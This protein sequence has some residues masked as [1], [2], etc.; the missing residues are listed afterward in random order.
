MQ[1]MATRPILLATLAV[2]AG[3]CATPC[4]RV[5]DS[6]DSFRRTQAPIAVR[7]PAAQAE[8]AKLAPG[9][10]L[11]LSIPFA[12][13]DAVTNRELKRLPSVPIP[14]PAVS[15][16]SLGSLRLAVDSVRM[17]AAPAGQLGFAIHVSLY[18]GKR[19]AFSLVVDAAVRPQLDPSQGTLTVSLSG[20]D[21]A[22]LDARIEG[23]ESKKLGQFIWSQ[24]P[25][26]A[27]MVLDQGTVTALAGELS[28]QLLAEATRRVKTELLDDLGELVTF[29]LDLP[30]ELPLESIAVSSQAAGPDRPGALDIDLRTPLSVDAALPEG[31]HPRA[32]G[33]HPNL[34]QVRMS[35]ASAAALANHAIREGRLP[36]RWTLEGEPDPK[37]T[38]VAGAGW[39]EG[40]RDA[41]EL[42][43]WNLEGDCAYV[44]LRGVPQIGVVPASSP[45][46]QPQ[47]E[48]AADS[49]RVESVVGSFKVRAGL[50]FKRAALRGLS[51]AERTA[52]HTE[53][54]IGGQTLR[55][56]V[57]SAQRS[58]DELILG[59]RLGPAR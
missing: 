28:E 23:G 29:E 6:R 25:D 2:L 9:P 47:L 44:V 53:V 16:Y 40:E 34:I 24:L 21:I 37:G 19:K 36:E 3:A 31:A 59:L 26:A 5:R 12:V 22:S 52:A 43:L 20:R 30:E 55:L 48:L 4:E 51:L 42:H 18:Q 35:G 13:V 8:Q 57:H 49:A 41:L 15:G 27:R 39:A 56:S 14:L 1:P 11:S 33:L 38:V 45:G 54:D 7:G 10:H 58:G 32:P 50:F 46:G 17:R